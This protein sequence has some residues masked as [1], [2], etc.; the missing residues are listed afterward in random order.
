MT[1]E[2]DAV[3]GEFADPHET[4]SKYV[5]DGKAGCETISCVGALDC[6]LT[7]NPPSVTVGDAQKLAPWTKRLV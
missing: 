3:F 6:T 1:T 5:A 4:T 7:T 2:K